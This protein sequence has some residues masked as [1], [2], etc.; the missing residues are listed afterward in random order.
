MYPNAV[1]E[2][3]CEAPTEGRQQVCSV[4]PIHIWNHMN[5]WSILLTGCPRFPQ[6]YSPGTGEEMG[7]L[8][9]D[10]WQKIPDRGVNAL[11][12]KSKA[13]FH[14]MVHINFHFITKLN[15]DIIETEVL[16]C[17]AATSW[18]SHYHSQCSSAAPIHLHL[19]TGKL[20]VKFQRH[21][22]GGRP[23]LCGQAS[24]WKWNSRIL[25]EQV[26]SYQ[27]FWIYS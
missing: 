1:A 21:W 12:P 19:Q 8:Q 15:C 2:R 6:V 27:G 13:G 24:M 9:D 5:L 25:N 20:G 7:K 14:I 11:K 17:Q 10:G 3:H 23:T 22:V 18:E 26:F 16:P 4:L